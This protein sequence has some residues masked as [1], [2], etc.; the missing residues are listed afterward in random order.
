MAVT[1]PWD[2]FLMFTDADVPEHCH[3]TTP[4]LTLLSR[5]SHTCIPTP[6]SFVSI[7]LGSLSILSW[8]F[9][10]LPQIIK[11]YRLGSTSG[12]SAFFLIEWCL[13][14]MSNLFGALLTNQATWQIL[15]GAYYC[16]VDIM[17]VG[18]W[19]WYE[20]LEHGRPLKKIWLSKTRARRRNESN[21]RS[22]STRQEVVEGIEPVAQPVILEQEENPT[23]SRNS[24]SAANAASPQ[25][26]PL[27]KASSASSMFHTPIYG[28]LS[29]ST[30][31]PGTPQPGAAAAAQSMQRVQHRHQSSQNLSSQNLPQPSPRAFVFTLTLLTLVSSTI[32]TPV[33]ASP[34]S[35][36]SSTTRTPNIPT[37]GTLLSWTS[38]ALYL[39]SRLPQLILNTRRR[40]TS[41]LSPHLFLAAFCGNLFYSSSL[42]LNPLAW[43][44]FGPYGG[45]GWAGPQ[46][47]MQSEWVSAAL[48]FWL[49]AAGVLG[50]DGAVGVQFWMYGTSLGDGGEEVLIVNGGEGKKGKGESRRKWKVRRVSGWMRGWQPGVSGR[51][52]PVL[53]QREVERR[54]GE[55][56]GLLHGSGGREGR[57]YGAV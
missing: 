41:G 6:L 21:D 47:S 42:L 35:T 28:F 19:V 53:G 51:I 46:G 48:P 20:E 39:A 33:S 10:Q 44:T 26:I 22:P 4:F 55:A 24:D 38:T 37:L 40:S 17:L 25:D 49:G 3:P 43:N 54:D 31:A 56:E 16:F 7:F 5:Y 32:L 13:G 36:L 2:P 34:A 18:Q 1:S 30:T 15:I 9:A 27:P 23:P 14:D 52:S 8:L 57:S 11:N 29:P 50:M 12:L 45:H